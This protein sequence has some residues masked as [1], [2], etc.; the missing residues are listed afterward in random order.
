MDAVAGRENAANKC[1]WFCLHLAWFWTMSEADSLSAPDNV[2]LSIY[3]A[4]AFLNGSYFLFCFSRCSC[5]FSS[6]CFASK[7]LI[8][9]EITFL[10]A[11]QEIQFWWPSYDL[12]KKDKN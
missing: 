9:N 1:Y 7:Q 4:F 5:L 3:K 11:F 2:P 6:T 12:A 10:G 8:V